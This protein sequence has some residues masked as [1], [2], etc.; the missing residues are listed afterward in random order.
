MAK[1]ALVDAAT[2]QLLIAIASDATA[3]SHGCAGYF[4][5]VQGGTETSP[6][7]K[8][9]ESGLKGGKSC[10]RITKR[11]VRPG[12]MPG[13]SAN[14]Y[15][16]ARCSSLTLSR[17]PSL[18]EHVAQSLRRPLPPARRQSSCLVLASR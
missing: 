18:A 10:N 3:T 11:E 16:H 8:F 14:P 17:E 6:F 4:G 15:S 1:P 13:V 2:K 7:Q 9:L 5:P 12:L